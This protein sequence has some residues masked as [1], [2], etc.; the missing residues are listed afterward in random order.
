MVSCIST[1]RDRMGLGRTRVVTLARGCRTGLFVI[2]ALAAAC[3]DGVRTVPRPDATIVP[4]APPVPDAPIVFDA[5]SPD[6]P[7]ATHI[8][9]LPISEDKQMAGL[10]AA[11]DV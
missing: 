10:G 11:V 1:R 3:G 8:D 4:D 9:E 6:G 7:V 2:A 5:P